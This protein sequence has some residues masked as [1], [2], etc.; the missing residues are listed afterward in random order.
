M[1][2]VNMKKINPDHWREAPPRE[3]IIK[4]NK[5]KEE[6]DVFRRT[7]KGSTKNNKYKR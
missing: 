4:R 7:N 5:F 6:S 3:K 2:Y 1:I